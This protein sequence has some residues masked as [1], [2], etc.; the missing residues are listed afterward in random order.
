MPRQLPSFPMTVL[1]TSLRRFT[2]ATLA[3][4]LTVSLPVTIT[5]A[6]H[7][8]EAQT[9]GGTLN[10]VVTPEPTTLVNLATN[11][12]PV[13]ANVTEGLRDHTMSPDGIASNFADAWIQR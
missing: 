4:L 12:M 6:A 8:A 9:R 1:L 3:T 13:S 10:V 7:I 2:R 5:L 11:V